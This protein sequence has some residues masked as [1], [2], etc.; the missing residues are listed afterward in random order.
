MGKND[1]VEKIP[2][3]LND[4][5]EALAQNKKILEEISMWLKISGIEKVRGILN[6]TL[7]T[8]EKI[9]VYHLS[10]GRGIT[11]IH[12]TTGMSVGSISNYWNSW[13]KLGLMKSLPVKGGERLIKNFD[14]EDYGITI[15][16]TLLKSQTIKTPSQSADGDTASLSTDNNAKQISSNGEN[17]I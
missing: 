7:N 15:P 2:A 12:N 10:D 17:S 13:N 6:S 11:E 1:N 16:K 8:P 14:L 5:T 9:S 3:T 4:V